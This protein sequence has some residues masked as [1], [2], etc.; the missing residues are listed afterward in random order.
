MIIQENDWFH[1][2]T[3]DHYVKVFSYE[4]VGTDDPVVQ[5]Y[6]AGANNAWHSTEVG[7]TIL[8]NG[9]VSITSN[10]SF[11]AKVIIV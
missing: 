2:E 8:N 6:K 9:S 10:S 4:E 7:I 3:E 5:V 1:D 11:K